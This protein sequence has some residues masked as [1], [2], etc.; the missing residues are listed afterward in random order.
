MGL[1]TDILGSLFEGLA[2]AVG[3]RLIQTRAGRI[4]A[5]CILL[6]VVAG[7]IWLIGRMAGWW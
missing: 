6:F 3:D 4:V 7:L 2:D 5:G 1:A